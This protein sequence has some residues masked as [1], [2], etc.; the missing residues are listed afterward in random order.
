MNK[1]YVGTKNPAKISAV[2][3]VFND[4]EVM[5]VEGVSNVRSQPLSEEETIDG[6]YN[7]AKSLPSGYRLGLEAGVTII[8]DI[9]YLINFG[10]LIDPNDS[11]YYA[12]GTYLPLPNYVKDK[13]YNEKM[14]LKDVMEEY[15]KVEKINERGGAISI[16][17]NNE[18]K[19]KDIFIHIC[20][21]LRGQLEFHK[22]K[23]NG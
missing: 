9:C 12:G 16:F 21:L 1:L 17:T 3:E 20:K 13:L 18:V 15:F 5:P 6:A 11:V 14:E 23:Q 10:V 7:R 22:E 4:F 8:K 2:V 19:R